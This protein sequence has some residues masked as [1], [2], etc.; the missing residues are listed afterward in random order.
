[1]SARALH[2]EV[3]FDAIEV[4]AGDRPHREDDPRG[5]REPRHER[6]EPRGDREPGEVA[7]LAR[8]LG[9]KH[10]IERRR[11][12]ARRVGRADLHRARSDEPVR[13][14]RKPRQRLDLPVGREDEEEGRDGDDGAWRGHEIARWTG[15]GV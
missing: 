2:P 10:P 7:Q 6:S 11:R 12:P 3:A 13:I 9:G 14:E 15:G 1:M 4:D 8:D 5:R